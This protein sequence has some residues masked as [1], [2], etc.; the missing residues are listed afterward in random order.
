M[1]FIKQFFHKFNVHLMQKHTHTTFLLLLKKKNEHEVLVIFKDLKKTQ[2]SFMSLKEIF[3]T[4]RVATMSS[5]TTLEY[6]V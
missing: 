1:K 4:Q 2:G 5:S 3:L 6:L